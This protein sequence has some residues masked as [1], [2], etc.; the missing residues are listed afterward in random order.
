MVKGSTGVIHTIFTMLLGCSNRWFAE[1]Y[2]V[3]YAWY[4]G[5]NLRYLNSG[6][7]YGANQVGA[8]ALL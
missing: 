6:S 4:F 8:V 2:G 7:V 1:R 3:R 5:G